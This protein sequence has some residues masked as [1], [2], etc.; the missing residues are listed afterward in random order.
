[1]NSKPITNIEVGV[2]F[3]TIF[4]FSIALKYAGTYTYGSRFHGFSKLYNLNL[5]NTQV[6]DGK[7]AE[8]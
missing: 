5:T 8:I 2:V 4:L 3:L 1:M 7:N 6:E